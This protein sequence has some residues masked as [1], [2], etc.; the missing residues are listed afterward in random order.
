MFAPI[1]L[2]LHNGVGESSSQSLPS[3]NLLPNVCFFFKQVSIASYLSSASC[4]IFTR[5][6]SILRQLHRR[7]TFP[8]T[9]FP[10]HLFR[11]EST[12]NRPFW[13]LTILVPD[14]I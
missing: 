5:I 13:R 2:H 12:Q 11:A 14:G 8:P 4:C 6:H 3:L 7:H 10:V 1:I 9:E